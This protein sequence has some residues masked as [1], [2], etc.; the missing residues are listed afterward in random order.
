MMMTV[1]M[2]RSVDYVILCIGQIIFIN[3]WAAADLGEVA[4]IP[5]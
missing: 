1:R 3:V 2:R 4:F 5:R